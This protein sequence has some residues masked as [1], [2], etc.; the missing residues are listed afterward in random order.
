M[1]GIFM[2]AKVYDVVKGETTKPDE[3]KHSKMPG[4]PPLITEQMSS[5]DAEKAT[6]YWTQFNIQKNYY[7]TQLVDFNCKLSTWT[8]GNSQAM[9]IFN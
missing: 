4:T 1:V 5:V 3:A 9:G 2:I 7:N 6:H 8:D